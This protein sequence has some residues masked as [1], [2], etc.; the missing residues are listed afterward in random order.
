MQFGSLVLCEVRIEEQI[1]DIIA[2]HIILQHRLEVRLVDVTALV[3]ESAAIVL[4]QITENYKETLSF[5]SWQT[6]KNHQTYSTGFFW[7]DCAEPKPP[8]VQPNF[9]IILY[10]ILFGSTVVSTSDDL[11]L[12]RMVSLFFVMSIRSGLGFG[13]NGN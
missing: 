7:P 13:C 9:L 5:F 10:P 2:A 1:A 12:Q 8:P 4:D 3:A 11:R 6:L